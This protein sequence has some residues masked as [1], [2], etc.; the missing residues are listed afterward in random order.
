[1]HLYYSVKGLKS[2]LP[3]IN[4]VLEMV[5]WNFQKGEKEEKVDGV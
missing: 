2:F 4:Y 3:N 5:D 1:L